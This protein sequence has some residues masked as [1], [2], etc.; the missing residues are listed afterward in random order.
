VPSKPERQAGNATQWV[1]IA[2]ASASLAS[3][4]ATLTTLIINAT[5]NN[6]SSSSK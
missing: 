1:S 6:I 2:S 4:A 3:V 5:R